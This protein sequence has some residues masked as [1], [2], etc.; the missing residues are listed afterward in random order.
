LGFLAF[1]QIPD[2]LSLIGFAVII[3]MGLALHFRR[4]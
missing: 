4:V 1:G 3:V 2:V